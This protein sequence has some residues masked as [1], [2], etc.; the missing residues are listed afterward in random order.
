M[1]R[2]RRKTIDYLH[3]R[4]SECSSALEAI[5]DEIDTLRDEEQEYYDAMPESLQGGDKGQAAEAAV[6]ELQSAYDRM[7]EVCT[8]VDEVLGHLDTAK[9]E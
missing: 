7:D 9:G 5:R 4:L 3:T 6:D 8:A 2:E 1:N